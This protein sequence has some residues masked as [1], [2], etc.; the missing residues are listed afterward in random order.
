M[1]KKLSAYRYAML[2]CFAFVFSFAL[3][4]IAMS[5]GPSYGQKALKNDIAPHKAIYKLRM[6][7]KN[8]ST[9]LSNISGEMFYE[10]SHDCSAWITD[11]R[12]NLFYEYADSPSVTVTTDFST[13]ETF[14]GKTFEFNAQRKR[15]GE[16][17]EETRGTAQLGKKKKN[18]SGEAVY[19]NPEGLVYQLPKGTVFPMTHTIRLLEQAKAGK[20]FYSTTV[21]DGSDEDGPVLIN[22]FIGK[23]INA[24]A[25]VSPSK[26]LE[27]TL[28]NTPAW[29]VR[30]AFFPLESQKETAD[31]EIDMVLHENGVISDM[32]IDYF[33]FS[34][35]QTLIAIE[36]IE[37]ENCNR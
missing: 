4:L 15:N 2:I 8:S 23:P 21:F 35:A 28:I 5:A 17:Y 1:S 18:P 7:S 31:Y 24:M 20:P 27:A 3:S 19:K 36:A 16:L 10:W 25:Q 22:A 6:I 30:M 29:K 9:Q 11:H 37:D 34:I 26:N 13:Y 33:E 12:F 14:S 32:T